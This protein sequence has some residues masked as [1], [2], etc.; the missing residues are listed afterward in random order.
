MDECKNNMTLM[1]PLPLLAASPEVE[2]VQTHTYLHNELEDPPTRLHGGGGGVGRGRGEG[3]RHR[4]QAGGS[5]L[6]T[7]GELV[8]PRMLTEHLAFMDNTQ[9]FVCSVYKLQ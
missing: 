9:D 7:L 8:E 5:Q 2:T 3:G 6:V 4:H 1:R